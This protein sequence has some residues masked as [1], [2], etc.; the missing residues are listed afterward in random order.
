MNSIKSMTRC[1][2]PISLSYCIIC[3]QGESEEKRGEGQG[4]RVDEEVG[5]GGDVRAYPCN[6]LDEV[7]VQL[8]TSFGIE[9]HGVGVANKV[10]G[11]NLIFS[12]ANKSLQQ[13]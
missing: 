7:R 3:Q 11:H 8:N 5:E 10:C 1:E 12:V 4:R 2:Y 13:Y 6:Q 9:G